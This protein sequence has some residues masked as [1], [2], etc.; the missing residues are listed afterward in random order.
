MQQIAPVVEELN[1]YP[2]ALDENWTSNCRPHLSSV[3]MR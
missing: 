2:G 1:P 3:P